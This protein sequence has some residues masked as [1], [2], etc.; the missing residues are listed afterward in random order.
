M[1]VLKAARAGDALLVFRGLSAA[2]SQ[3][4]YHFV[5]PLVFKG[6]HMQEHLH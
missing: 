6:A 1:D 4:E 2:F 3:I 5:S